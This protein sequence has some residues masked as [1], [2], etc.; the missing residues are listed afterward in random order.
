MFQWLRSGNPY[1]FIYLLFYALIVKFYYLTH[2]V[3]PVFSAPSDG[4]AYK[5]FVHWLEN[6]LHVGAE[7]FTICAIL[8]ILVEG[9]VLN[10]QIN[11]FHILPGTTHFTAFS[12]ILFSGFLDSWNAFS[13]PL[14]AGM[15][16]LALVYQLF[17]LYDTPRP[18]ATAFNLG[19]TVGFA[20]LLYFPAMALLLVVWFSF[21]SMRPF[22]L[23]E[24]ILALLGVLCPYYFIATI[25]FLTGHW[26]WMKEIPIPGFSIPKLVYSYW[27]LSGMTGLLLYF[28]YGSFRLQ[29]DYTKMLIHIRKSWTALLAF[30]IVALVLPFLPDVFRVD[31][32]F[33]A[34]IPMSIF[35]ACGFFHIKK[36]G[37]GWFLHLLALGFVLYIQWW[38]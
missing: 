15:F 35:I 32:W 16:M 23:S 22:R 19:L 34:F 11:R 30:L 25:F 37:L 33:I 2:P 21:V 8:L 10:A 36:R 27:I 18:R 17:K 7:G 29:Q 3:E 26:D 12:F 4:L 1:T 24:W 13:A 28:I 6:T 20:S 31:G 9:I 38:R 5:P 14:V